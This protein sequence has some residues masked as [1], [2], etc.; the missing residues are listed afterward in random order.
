MAIIALTA[1]FSR[2]SPKLVWQHFHTRYSPRSRLRPF[3]A[4]GKDWRACHRTVLWVSN[5]LKRRRVLSNSSPLALSMA[6]KPIAELKLDPRNPRRHPRKQIEKI[7][8]S[9]QEFGFRVPILIE[10]NGK[11]IAGH[12]RTEAALLAGL[13]AVP[14]I[15]CDDLTEAQ[16]RAFRIADNR[17]AEL[18]GWTI[19]VLADE[20]QGL[21]DIQFDIDLT[22]FDT[23]QIDGILSGA[24]ASKAPDPA[25]MVPDIS[26]EPAISRLG[27]TWQLGG[28]HLLVCGDALDAASYE[29]ALG[30]KKAQM[31]F[32][33]PP[34]NVPIAGHVSGLGKA[35][36][37]E[38]VMASGEMSPQ[39]FTAFLRGI[40][41]KLTAFTTDGAISFICMDWRHAFELLSACRET[42]SELKNI[43]VWAKNNGG[44]GSLYRS[45]H[46][47]VFMFKTGAAPHINNVQLGKAGRWRS[48]VWDYA[49]ANSFG[50]GRDE[51]LEMHPTV[52]PIAMVAD[53][54]LDVSKRNGLVLDPFAGSGTTIM[55]AEKT[56]RR[57]AAIELDPHYV[58]V[59]VRRFQKHT[60]LPVV[61][62]ETGQTFED[63]AAQRKQDTEV[64]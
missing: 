61:F 34:Y 9:I 44:M 39:E 1:S 28:K 64:A 10:H 7:A 27:D 50:A 5:M 25:D 55:A 3:A 38:F 49:G 6:L 42:F 21:I 59:S 48:N 57:A 8:A 43:C 19:E 22:G 2:W 4:N 12:A 17:L 53:A 56:G 60:G 24:E 30:G 63:V 41:E 51:M 37:G 40:A 52:K 32:T 11:V 36:H 20:L 13:D 29:R 46:E 45:Q 18:G 58:D 26:T 35:Q 62:V 15:V 47:L 33:D 16:I 23:A 14:V 54:I 31:V